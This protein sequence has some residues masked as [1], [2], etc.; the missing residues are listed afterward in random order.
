[1][2]L[3]RFRPDW[4]LVSISTLISLGLV[5][6]LTA[7]NSTK[8]SS[9]NVA[10]V[11]SL[12]KT[13]TQDIQLFASKPLAGW[14]LIVSDTESQVPL[15]GDSVIVPKLAQSRAPN[16]QVSANL[17]NKDGTKDAVNL[18][19]KD[20]WGAVISIEGGAPINVA[21]YAPSG[22][23]SFDI[24]VKELSQAGLAFKL[25]CG[26]DCERKLPYLFPGRALQGKGWQHLV[27][28]LS[29]F[30]RAD[31]DLSGV[32]RPF[33][34]ESGA[35]GELSI[36][37]IRY[38][39][40]GTPNT[41]CPDFKT[42]SVTPDMLNEAWSISWWLPRHE[43]KLRQIKENS[44]VDLVFIGDSITHGWEKDGFNIWQKFY[45]KRDPL[46]LGFSGDRTENVLWRLQH[47]EV[48]GIHPKAA[49]LMFGTNNT[50]HRLEDPNTTALGIKRNIDELQKRLPDTKILLLAIF[51][52]DEQPDAQMRQINDQVNKII[53]GY[54]DNKKIFF[55]DINK[56]F[57]DDKG[58]LHKEIMPDLLHPNEKGYEIWAKAME[59]TLVTLLK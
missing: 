40:T 35:T 14:Q 17:I 13:P 3:S 29:C 43:Q 15:V 46:D 18:K 22:V 2:I 28:S 20:A 4:R 1:M 16:S 55:L 44:K 19:W 31:D 30:I 21:A 37:N 53:S 57:L 9:H 34:L 47:G 11:S 25:T 48:D 24:N 51:P 59:P 32:T 56:N 23:L 58:I 8:S 33:V 52:R 36:A 5:A 49:V 10:S 7:C 12:A 54:A 38:E 42:A 50:G 41:T 27:F 6:G 26:K 45:A 39:M